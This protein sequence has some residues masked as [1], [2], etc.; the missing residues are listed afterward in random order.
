MS[1]KVKTSG[2]NGVDITPTS[3]TLST[4][5]T[6]AAPT[7]S[8]GDGD[9]GFYENGANA[10]YLS[11]G[12]GDRWLWSGSSFLAA[13]ANGPTMISAASSGTAPN[14]LPNRADNNTGIGSVAVDNLSLITGG[15]EAVRAE[16]PADLGATETSLWV[17]DLDNGA[18][19]QVSV[20]ADDSGGAGFKVLR[21]AN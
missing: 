7:L 10:V 20:G 11:L 16:D 6:A 17:F 19:Q 1:V 4:G 13:H 3:I 8:W 21:I 2:A 14:I 9:T 5:G 15:L 18:L 12:G